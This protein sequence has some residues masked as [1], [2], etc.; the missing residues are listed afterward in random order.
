MSV[1]LKTADFFEGHVLDLL[2]TKL[3]DEV[4]IDPISI[5]RQFVSTIRFNEEDRDAIREDIMSFLKNNREVIY[6]IVI[7]PSSTKERAKL[8]LREG[9][10]VILVNVT[11]DVSDATLTVLCN[12]ELDL[13][14]KL[15]AFIKEH[16]VEEEEDSDDLQITYIY[17]GESSANLHNKTVVAQKLSEIEINYSAQSFSALNALKDYILNGVDSCKIAFITGVSGTGKTFALQSLMQELNQSYKI[18]VVYDACKFLSDLSLYEE[19]TTEYIDQPSIYIFDDVSFADLNQLKASI[20]SLIGGLFSNTRKDVF[21]FT[22]DNPISY[23]DKAIVREGRCIAQ[24]EL[25]NLS[26]VEADNWLDFH[27]IVDRPRKLK[28]NLSE[29]YALK[30]GPQIKESNPKGLI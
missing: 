25:G 20:T 9:E 15:Q 16:E 18:I 1:S 5:N 28:G 17:N 4:K 19:I 12:S 26:Q 22:S 8:I 10:Y 29:L 13:H 2:S 7:V 3:K 21:I 6:E 23:I 11:L 30:D 27:G 24:I 14:N